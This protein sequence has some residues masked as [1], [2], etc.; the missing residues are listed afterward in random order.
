VGAPGFAGFW[1]RRESIAEESGLHVTQIEHLLSRHGS[2][3]AELLDRIRERPELGEP[4]EGAE[5]YLAVEAHYAT[6]HEG[7]LHLDDVLTR[8]TR[9]SI[10]TFDRGLAAA[11]P[12]A[13][14]MGEVLG[15]DEATRAREIR[16][17]Q[18][19]VAAERESQ[20]QPDDRT[21]DA[22]RLGAPDV[23]MGGGGGAE[24]L[25]LRERAETPAE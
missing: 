22:A 11:R 20:E 17:Y 25:P 13:R 5:S 7:A 6:A 8:R 3:V 12:I 16:H 15:W 23:R 9:I 18:A 4:I 14:L 19:R 21:A 24:V 10:E 1:N 2:R